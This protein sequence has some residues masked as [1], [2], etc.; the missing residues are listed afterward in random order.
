MVIGTKC[1]VTLLD[2]SL[3]LSPLNGKAYF[4]V[5]SKK[6]SV[7]IPFAK[8][9]HASIAKQ[10]IE[11]DQELQPHAVIRELTLDG[12]V[13]LAYVRHKHAL[14]LPFSRIAQHILHSDRPI[15]TTYTQLLS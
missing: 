13:L 8:P 15:G 1:E 11:V 5:L 3:A 2:I 4:L 9:K 10:V 6:S 14:F 7:R 12:D